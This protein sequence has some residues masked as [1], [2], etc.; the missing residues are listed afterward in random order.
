MEK[1]R[2]FISLLLTIT[3]F[4]IWSCSEE[5]STSPHDGLLDELNLPEKHF[6]YANIELPQHYTENAFPPQTRFQRAAIEFDNTPPNNPLTDAGA[7]LGRVLF[8]DKKLSANGTVSCSSCHQQQFGFDD[9]R[10]LSEGFEGGHTRRHSMGLTNA[11]FYFSGKFFWDERASTLEEQVLMPFQ[12][13]VEMGLTLEELEQIVSEQPYYPVL[14]KDAFGNETVTSDKIS[15]ALAQFVRS[16]V[17]TNSKYDRARSEVPSPLV[18]FPG[19]TEQE[20]LGKDL[21][22]L[23]IAL[24]NGQQANCAGCHVSEAFL[25]PIPPGRIGTTTTVN[26]GLDAESTDDLGVFET[27]GN[28]NDIGKFKVPSLRNIA[29]RRGYM[30]DGRFETLEEVLDFYSTGIQN[31]PNLAPP[32]LG[33]DGQAVKFNLTNEEKEA[34]IAFLHTLTDHEMLEDEKYSDPFE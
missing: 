2:I 34:I 18:N 28:P 6:N 17:S 31:H 20:N 25:S 16:L 8:Y 22:Y 30:H 1:K 10:T 12:D 26:N 29:V 5:E 19:F 24:E 7:T 27:T 23:P 11:R 33:P 9:P 14:F 13:P 32:L 21:F 3:A 15:K 4:I